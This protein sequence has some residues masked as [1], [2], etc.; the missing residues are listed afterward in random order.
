MKSSISLSDQ[1]VILE[2]PA[3]WSHIFLWMIMLVSTSAI[4]WAYFA[5]IEQTVP[6]VGQLEFSDGAR[7]IQAPTTGAVVRLH[8]ENGDRVVKNQPLLTFSPTNPSADLKSLEEVKKTLEQEN[9][10]YQGV[11]GGQANGQSSPELETLIK[12]REA[13]IGENQALQS[14]LDELYNGQ[15]GIGNYNPTLAGLV[16]NYRAE[17]LSRINTVQLQIQELQKQLNQAEDAESAARQQL[18]VAQSQLDYAQNQ[19]AYSQ[20][21]LNSS[22]EQLELAKG[23]LEKSKEVLGSNERILGRL[24]PLVE[25]GAIAELQ[26]DRQQQEVLRGET[27]VLRQQDQIEARLGEINQRQGEINTRRGE[28]NARQ[29]E[30]SRVEAEIQNQIGEQERLKV[31]M[32]RTAEQLQNTRDAWARELYTRIEENKKA[33]ASTDA[34]LGRYKLE[35]QKRLSEIN[36]QVEKAGQQRDT[37]ILR[38][39]SAGIIYELA[40]STKDDSELDLNQDE[41]C[42]YIVSSILQPGDPQPKRCEEA[43]YEAQQTEKLLQ[44]L[45]DDGGLEAVVYVQNTDVA[46]VLNALRNKR[47]KLVPYNN[48]EIAGEVIE[49]TPEKDCICPESEEARQEIGLNDRD[50]LP[51]ELNIDAFPAGEFGTVPGELK[52]I[53]Q[54]AIPPDELRQ[55]FSFKAK[56][57][58]ER[59]HFVLN[60]EEDIQVALQAG[61]AVNSKVNIGKR[62]VLQMLF[63]RLTG[64]FNSV[65]D[66][67]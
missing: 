65:T 33:I 40:P 60:K 53:S 9:Q 29:G 43:Y 30:I 35:N 41:I 15:G 1:P 21:Q 49:C 57:K 32:S 55:Y 4:V 39:P 62:T 20:E 7:E 26:K 59:E 18:L 50:C 27:E 54:E 46:L 14:L 25:E 13:R 44:I 11:V 8:V 38:A 63:S 6:A 24:D 12:E 58:L 5:R 61:M 52:W 47:E 64:Q 22:R 34:Q 67:R 28:V 31:A 17:Y 66:V 36:A 56:V 23:Q 51:V 19:L 3:F 2:K 37:Q 45:D 48:Q 16:S 10:F 42:Q